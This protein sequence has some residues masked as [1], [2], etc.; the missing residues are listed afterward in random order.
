MGAELADRGLV[1]T[2]RHRIIAGD[3]GGNTHT[4]H[5]LVVTRE[6][7]SR[8]RNRPSAPEAV[9]SG[10]ATE[11]ARARTSRWQRLLGPT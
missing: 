7:A 3:S 5:L 9:A 4:L 1:A 11:S 2:T 6:V 8:R 10:D